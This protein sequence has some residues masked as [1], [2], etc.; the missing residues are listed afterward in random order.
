MEKSKENLIQDVVRRSGVNPRKCMK[1]GKCSG[2]CP[3]YD[4]MEY[5]PHQFVYMIE[6]GDIEPLLKSKSIYKCLTCFACVD[7]CPR[8]VEPAKLIESIRLSVI[9]EQGN[10]HLTPQ[11][12]PELIDEEMPQQALVTA[13]RKYTK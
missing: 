6:T 8:G 9:R 2:T 1:C 4:E 12:I 13:F 11:M 7:R 10:N 5:H 3:A